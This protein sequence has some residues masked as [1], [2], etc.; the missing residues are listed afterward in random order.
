[1]VQA[2]TSSLLEGGEDILR[3]MLETGA[4]HPSQSLWCNTVVLVCKKDRS[5][6]F[7][8]DFHRL[9]AHMKKDSYPLLRI[10][11]VLESMAGAR[12]FSMIDFKNGFWQVHMAPESQQ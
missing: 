3:D 10:Q 8:V 12:H 4:I 9:N 11:E 2:D 7:C 6:R 1:M 5:L